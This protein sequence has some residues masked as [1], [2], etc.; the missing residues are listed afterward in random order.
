MARVDGLKPRHAGVRIPLPQPDRRFWMDRDKTIAFLT[1][2]MITES[3]EFH[4][5]EEEI[6]EGVHFR[7]LN[8]FTDEELMTEL[9]SRNYTLAD[10]K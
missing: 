5:L 2:V 4:Y 9:T 3:L 6:R 8:S 10:V 1:Q 7:G